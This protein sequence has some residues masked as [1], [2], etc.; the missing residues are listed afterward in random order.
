MGLEAA[1]H[2]L[3]HLA[4]HDALTGLPNRVLLD[5]RLDQAI[6]HAERD[7]SNSRCWCSIS[8]A[9]SSSTIRSAIAP[10][11]NCSTRSRSACAASSASLDTV[12]RMG[13]DEFVLVLAPRRTRPDA[14][15]VAQRA[16][17]AF[18]GAGQDR[19]RRPAHLHQHRHRFLSRPTARYRGESASRTP[20][21]RCTAPSSAGATICSASSR[22]WTR[23]TRERVK[24]ESDLH[25]RARAEAI[26]A[27]L[28]AE[29]RYRDGRFPQRRSAD[30]LAASGARHDHAG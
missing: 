28:P 13:G 21:P 29:G 20:T 18:E 19:R 2:Q 27:A 23:D 7:S 22:A 30:P 26:R 4:T 8:I 16:I 10:V 17:D 12:A 3:R 9:S 11:M 14:E 15:R 5:D 25:A 6:V 1:N 24:L